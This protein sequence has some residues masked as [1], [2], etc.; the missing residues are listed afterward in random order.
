MRGLS[1]ANSARGNPTE[2]DATSSHVH[3]K[4]ETLGQK[5]KNS[6]VSTSLKVTL[7][8]GIIGLLTATVKLIDT[9]LH[10]G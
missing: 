6:G 1:R 9:L 8:T 5:D 7:I 10:L 2:K 4:K 3:K